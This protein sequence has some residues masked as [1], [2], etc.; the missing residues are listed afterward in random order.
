MALGFE[1]DRGCSPE[2]IERICFTAT[3]ALSYEACERIA[4]K[5]GVA[6]SDSTIQQYVCKEGERVQ[7]LRDERIEEAVNPATRSNVVRQAAK[8]CRGAEFSLVIMLDGWF[9]RE[10]GEQWGLKPPE[11][12]ANRIDWREVKTGVVFRREDQA[13]TQSGRGVILKKH[14]EA[15]RTDARDFG[16][17]LYALALAHG[18]HQAK[19]VFVVAD[20]GVWIWKI[21]DERFRGARQ[22]LDFYHASQHLHAVAQAI[23]PDPEKA[24]KW[25]EPLLH[26]LKNGGENGVIESLEQLTEL[27]DELE[28]QERSETVRKNIEYFRQHRDRIQYKNM[29]KHGCPIGSGAIES[30][31]AQLQDRFKRTGQYWTPK[32]EKSLMALEIIRRNEQWNEFW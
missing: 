27:I 11:K 3:Q 21:A 7:A 28:S 4:A 17:R 8:R 2:L 6:V 32:G 19:R 25:V 14:Y 31:C 13:R 23:H 30:T 1:D 5:W 12:I 26:Q 16:R 29:A 18:L 9:V 22:L 10:R 15:R 24:K 20:G